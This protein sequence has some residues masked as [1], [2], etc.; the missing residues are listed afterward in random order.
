MNALQSLLQNLR[1]RQGDKGDKGDKGDE[2]DSITS[3][4]LRIYVKTVSGKVFQL[5]FTKRPMDFIGFSN[6]PTGAFN[7]APAHSPLC[8][9]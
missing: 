2:I 9:P 1:G 4:D 8:T 3:D 7:G 6:I 5:P